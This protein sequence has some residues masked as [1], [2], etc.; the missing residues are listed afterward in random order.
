[1]R[2]N[3]GV[4]FDKQW[5]IT[6]ALI[7]QTWNKPGVLNSVSVLQIVGHR[8]LRTQKISFGKI[9]VGKDAAGNVILAEQYIDPE[10]ASAF[11]EMLDAYTNWTSNAVIVLDSCLLGCYTKDARNSVAQIIANVTG[12]PVLSPGGYSSGS[13]LNDTSRVVAWANPTTKLTVYETLDKEAAEAA[14]KDPYS[15]APENILATK[16][17]MYD[18]QNDVWY[19]T[20][21]D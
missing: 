10:N 5:D 18:S 19:L 13:L 9:P 15:G 7:D 2:R 21:P 16:A 17:I 20:F 3:Y 4:P 12:R 1:M 14:K 11:A 6:K 8:T